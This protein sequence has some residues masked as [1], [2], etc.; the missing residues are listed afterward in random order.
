MYH[1]SGEVNSLPVTKDDHTTG[2][3]NLFADTKAIVASYTDE[4]TSNKKFFL[5]TSIPLR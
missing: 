3:A 1:N 4:T 5:T 2:K